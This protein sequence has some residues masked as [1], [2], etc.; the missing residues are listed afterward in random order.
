MPPMHPF[1]KRV[2][3]YDT[4]GQMVEQWERYFL[5]TQTL[6][7]FILTGTF[8]NPLTGSPGAVAWSLEG[9][10]ADTNEWGIPGAPGPAGAAGPAGPQGLPG[11]DGDVSADEPWTPHVVAGLVLSGQSG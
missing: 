5:A 9:L 2:P 7:N 3:M 1:P 10:G 8:T 6:I 11:A 4:N